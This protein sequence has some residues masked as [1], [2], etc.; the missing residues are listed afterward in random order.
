MAAGGLASGILKRQLSAPKQTP[1]NPGRKGKRKLRTNPLQENL[2]KSNTLWHETGTHS[3]GY[4]P[5]VLSFT[6][7]ENITPTDVTVC[8]FADKESFAALYPFYYSGHHELLW[9][10]HEK[11][12]W[13]WAWAPSQLVVSLI[14]SSAMVL[15]LQYHGG[16]SRGLLCEEPKGVI[17]LRPPNP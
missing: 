3:S 5:D 4:F 9:H 13:W 1:P 15:A 8:N 14:Q 16:S 7:K 6:K 17:I 12:D 2:Q 10:L 11:W